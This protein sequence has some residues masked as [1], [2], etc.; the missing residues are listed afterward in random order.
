MSDNRKKAVIIGGGIS[1]LSAAYYLQKEIKEKGLPIDTMLI[2]ASPRLGGKVQTFTKDGFTVEQGP[3]SFLARKKSMARLVEEVGMEDRLVNNATG[4]SYVLVDG[5]LHSMPEGSFMG[6]PTK[7][8]PFAFSGMFSWPGKFRAAGDFVLPRSK[9]AEDQ[10]LGHFFRRRLGDDVVEN[11]IEPLLSGI[12]ASDLDKLSLM[13]TFPNF[14]NL[15]QKYRSLV[16]GIKKTMP[17]PKTGR[18]APKKKGMFLTVNTGLESFIRA[19]EEK[20]EEGTVLKNTKVNRIIK[21]D[22]GYELKLD[23]KETVT[24]DGIIIAA[25][26]QAVHGMMPE[27]DF[28]KPFEEMPATS[29]ATVAM[30]FPASAVKQDIDGT[31]FVVS[32]NSDFRIT[33]CTWTHKKWP[34]TTPEG[35][36]LLR[37]YVGRPSD[38]SIVDESDEEITK[39][40]LADLNKIMD[41]TDEPE[42]SIVTRWKDAMPQYTV[43]H[44]ARFES[45]KKDMDQDLPG[46]YLAGGSYEGVGLPD[47]IDQGEE[48]VEKIISFLDERKEN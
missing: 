38:E 12:Y 8:L 28:F 41:I 22:D 35:K 4:K 34:H 26:H 48:A 30:A 7:I 11:L 24:A 37:C 2:E 1:G 14:Y 15:E 27:Y 36:V 31:G 19:V 5:K 9:P 46:I 47:C 33:A 21:T 10:S 13:S 6:I 39:I 40:V 23:S 25:P 3:D 44:K 43:G 45:I 17:A 16:L 29:V 32:R 42:F 18:A 20:L